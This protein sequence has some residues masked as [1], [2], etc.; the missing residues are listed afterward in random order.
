M[1]KN[2]IIKITIIVLI[3][4]LTQGCQKQKI[5]RY[6]DM[7]YNKKSKQCECIQ[8]YSPEEIPALSSTEYNSCGSIVRNFFTSALTM[9][10]IPT[11]HMLEIPSNSVVT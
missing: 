9:P 4:F 3:L 1:I 2:E 5:C 7:I 6:A 10:T 11:I 8:A